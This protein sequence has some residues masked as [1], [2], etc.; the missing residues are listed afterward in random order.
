M[1]KAEECR[2]KANQYSERAKAASSMQERDRALRMKRSYDLMA[3]SADFD[4][5][6]G[7]VIRQLKG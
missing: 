6:L 7:D 3:R 4:A 2:L 5:A 1:R